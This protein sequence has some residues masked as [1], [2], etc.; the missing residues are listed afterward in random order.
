MEEWEGCN[1]AGLRARGCRRRRRLGGAVA[2]G[3]RRRQ[4]DASR[5]AA[6]GS[7]VSS[8][9]SAGGRRQPAHVAA[10]ASR[11][12]RS[13][14]GR[15]RRERDG[16]P[17]KRA[18]GS[19]DRHG[20]GVWRR[21]IGH[22]RNAGWRARGATTAHGAAADGRRTGSAVRDHIRVAAP[23]ADLLAGAR[24]RFAACDRPA[25]ASAGTQALVTAA[26]VTPSTLPKAAACAKAASIAASASR[27]SG[28]AC[29]T[30][31]PFERHAGDPSDT[32]N[33]AVPSSHVEA[34]SGWSE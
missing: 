19:F 23:A 18:G 21:R 28:R 29:D 2:A 16:G 12:T 1:S 17:R 24:S 30:R 6:R 22:R 14:S 32:G 4:L 33:P 15:S 27:D 26:G 8:T 13:C 5:P 31:Q 20:T 34:R 9:S 10:F 25:L 11:L 3:A 7:G